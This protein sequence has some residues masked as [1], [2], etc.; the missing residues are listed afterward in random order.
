LF[1]LDSLG[2]K[3]ADRDRLRE[4]HISPCSA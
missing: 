3:N 1:N 2:G 4:W